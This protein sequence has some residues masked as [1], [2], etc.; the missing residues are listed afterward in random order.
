[1][2]K[3]EALLKIHEQL[4]DFVAHKIEGTSLCLRIKNIINKEL[5]PSFLESSICRQTGILSPRTALEWILDVVMGLRERNPDV[6]DCVKT[7]I[8]LIERYARDGLKFPERNCD[9]YTTSEEA[10][11][12]IT[13]YCSKMAETDECVKSC[14]YRKSKGGCAFGWLL[15][16]AGTKGENDG[17]K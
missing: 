12:A 6:L 13:E 9:I 10:D 3:R 11:R 7:T 1:M 17:S 5:K 8:D 4:E 2:T 16:A 14:P 15:A